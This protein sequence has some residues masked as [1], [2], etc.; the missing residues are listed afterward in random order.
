MSSAAPYRAA[1]EPRPDS[2]IALLAPCAG[3]H[4]DTEIEGTGRIRVHP[5]KPRTAEATVAEF[6]GCTEH[7]RDFRM[8]GVTFDRGHENRLVRSAVGFTVAGWRR[9]RLTG[10]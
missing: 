3:G 4:R 9:W 6:F 2:A 1:P 7:T 10:W 8:P 5:W